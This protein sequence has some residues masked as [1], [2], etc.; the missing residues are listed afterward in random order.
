MTIGTMQYPLHKNLH[1]LAL[2][3]GLFPLSFSLKLSSQ[4]NVFLVFAAWLIK[5]GCDWVNRLQHM[6]RLLALLNKA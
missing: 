4:L 3:R 2:S 6:P 5:S 1:N